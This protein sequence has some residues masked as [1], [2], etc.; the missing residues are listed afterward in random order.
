MTPFMRRIVWCVA[1]G[2]TA[3]VGATVLISAQRPARSPSPPGLDIQILLDRAGFSPGEIDGRNGT[4]FR[5][6]VIAFQEARGLAPGARNRTALLEALGAGTVDTMVSYTIT[7][8]DAAGPFTAVMPSDMIEKSKLP[9]M[10]YASVLEAL[11]EKFHAAPRLLKRL[12]P[13][14]RF[15]EGEQIRV[16]NVAADKEPASHGEPAGV[17]GKVVPTSGRQAKPASAHTG[18]VTVVVSKKKS[19]LTVSDR[20]NRIVFYAPVTSGSEHDPLPI[21]TWAVASV[22]RN[23]IFNYNPALFWDADPSSAN[24]TLPA[25]PNNPVGLVWIDIT[26]A[27]YGMHGTP[28]PASIGHS[29]SHGCVRLTNWDA[30]TLAGLVKKGT[31]VVFEE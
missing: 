5:K 7:R 21:G 13:G 24:A 1:A 3:L 2:A 9:S 10:N 11:G 26:K 16:P 29:A 4:N 27:H 17:K 20:N 18:D 19:T 30:A 23:P 14:A 15:T 12:N 31:R 8:E 22:S 28:E 25:G 6:A